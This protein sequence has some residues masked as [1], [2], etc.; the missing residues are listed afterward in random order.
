MTEDTT[1][2][3]DSEPVAGPVQ[4]PVGPLA[5]NRGLRAYRLASDQ[6]GFERALAERWDKECRGTSCVNGGW[7]ALDLLCSEPDITGTWLGLGYGGRTPLVHLDDTHR[8]VAA[9]VIQWLGTNVGRSFLDEAFKAAGYTLRY[10]K[11]PNAEVSG[12][13]A[14]ADTR[15][16]GRP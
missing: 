13:P 6:L 7:G 9:T 15:T 14:T 4:R 8:A 16:T 12:G 5:P 10:E 2:D 11:R 3:T 1:P